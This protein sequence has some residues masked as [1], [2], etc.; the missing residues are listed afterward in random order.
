MCSSEFDAALLAVANF[1]D[2]KSP[3]TL[4]HAPAVAELAAEAGR[5]Y[6]L[7]EAEVT[8]LRRAGLVHGFGR[9]G[10]SNSIW[11]RT[12][13]LGA[14]DWERVR[15]YPYVTERMLHQ[16]PSLSPLGE[17]AV[18][19]RERLDGSGYPRGLSGNA[20]T[21]SARV[22]S[23]AE[24]YQTKRE[25]RPHRV[26]LPAEEAAGQLRA[27]AQAARLEPAAVDA[28][29][30]AAGHR[31][32]RRQDSPRG[33]TS[34]EIDVLRLLARGMSNK[35]IAHR[36]VITPKTASNHVEH[37]YA[38]IDATGRASAAMFAMQHGLLPDEELAT[39]DRTSPS[40]EANASC[41]PPIASL[42]SVT[43]GR[44]G[45]VTGAQEAPR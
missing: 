7:D 30:R 9:L 23:A 36:L 21:R 40:D 18:L 11:D 26:A 3:Y 35:Q 28:V 14:G 22:L 5:Q 45:H 31:V 44:A 16:S 33:L 6:G 12:G 1:I 15:M 4:G 42:G 43:S 39:A 24:A 10:V 20:I 29:L 2:L 17:I 13:P 27:E 32:P 34:R 41:A 38:K 8:T 19:H 25:A 37:I